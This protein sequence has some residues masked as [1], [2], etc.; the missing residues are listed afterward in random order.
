MSSKKDKYLESAQRFIIKG[1]LD[2]AAKDL[3]QAISF[4]PSDIKVRQRMAEI[5]VR[6]NRQEEAISEYETIGKYFSDSGFYLKAI[7]VYKQIQK[8]AP[9]KPKTTLTL[10]ELNVKQGLVGNALAEFN[11]LVNLYVKKGNFSDALEVLQ[12]M[13]EIDP[14]NAN[15]ILKIAET[16]YA[17]GDRDQAYDQYINLAEQLF[18]RKDKTPVYRLGERISALFPEKKWSVLSLASAQLERGDHHSA[19]ASLKEII[20]NAPDNIE[21]WY[22][23]AD[24]IRAMGETGQYR[25]A[26]T[27]ISQRFPQEFRPVEELIE[28]AIAHS[29]LNTAL[30]LL[31]AHR[32]HLL[33]SGRSTQIEQFYIHLDTYAPRSQDVME[34]LSWLYSETADADKLQI[35]NARILSLTTPPENEGIE[36]ISLE[37]AFEE[38]LGGEE[39]IQQFTAKV[40]A[41]S[42]PE[43]EEEISLD[44]DEVIEEPSIQLA[45]A[46]PAELETSSESQQPEPDGI[47]TLEEPSEPTEEIPVYEESSSSVEIAADEKLLDS[48]DISESVLG[49]QEADRVTLAISEPLSFEAF[50]P[51]PEV[52]AP[53]TAISVSIEPP[54]P[55]EPLIANHMEEIQ[56]TE[57]DLVSLWEQSIDEAMAEE[58]EGEQLSVEPQI[59]VSGSTQATPDISTL[60]TGDLSIVSQIEASSEP[61]LSELV[62]ETEI[63]EDQTTGDHLEIESVLDD[64]D[65]AIFS[66]ALFGQD[67]CGSE[68]EGKY[69]LGDLLTAFKKGVDEQVDESDTETHYSLGIAYK[70]MGLY[71]EA[72]EEFRAAAGD[73]S[74]SA[75]CACLE[76]ICWRDKGDI[77]A[78]ENAFKGGLALPCLTS[79]T[80]L[81]LK[82]ELAILYELSSRTEEAISLYGEILGV[83]I[84]FRDVSNRLSN[85]ADNGDLDILEPELIE[86]DEDS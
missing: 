1:Q 83:N 47:P 63:L 68:D 48:I 26:L 50:L 3:E 45:D 7:A 86:L 71:D 5:L 61:I 2:K 49:L 53:E 77:A 22:L 28:L 54:V 36:K 23:L 41:V 20:S 14:G 25:Q 81:N 57:P 74:R 15:T 29:D 40:A 13:H 6:L 11:Q 85:L 34:G 9:E 75:D 80:R 24:A 21:A 60:P 56:K 65:L 51:P 58:P 31:K 27:K 39:P 55:E 62:L 42:E 10:G 66:E 4:D 59:P 79:E 43:W 73:S 78:A 72:V 12:R 70:E 30:E 37:E 38:A 8:L 69:G 17:S 33:S 35:V 16:Y 76:G 84:Y 19:L 46:V 82:Y 18:G 44:I 64:E 67:E 32:A 52:T